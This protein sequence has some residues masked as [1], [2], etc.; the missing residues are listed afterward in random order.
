TEPHG[1]MVV[2]SAAAATQLA[3]GQWAGSEMIGL[4]HRGEP[5]E[6]IVEVAHRLGKSAGLV[7]DTRITHATPAGFAAHQPNRSMENEIAVD[8]LDNR[9]EVMMGGGLRHWT[10]EAAGEAGSAAHAA[11]VQL[12]GGAY[13]GSSRRRDNRN[14]LLEARHEHGYQLAFDRWSLAAVESM[15]LLGV[16]ADSEMQDALLERAARRDE[17]TRHEPSLVEMTAKALELLEQDPDGFFLIVE[18]GQ[19]VWCGHNNGAGGMLHELLR[20][21]AAVRYVLDWARQ[22]DDTLVLVTADHET[23]GFGFS[24]S[25]RPLPAPQTL[26]GEA[27]ADEKFQPNFNY[28][29]PEALDLLYNQQKSFFSMMLEFDA[30]P[31]G[32]QTPEALVKIVNSAS[33]AKI[34]L[35]DAVAVLTRMRNRNYVAGHPF[36]NAPTVPQIRDFESFYV[37]GENLRMNQLGRRLAAQQS[38][39]WSSGTHTSTPVLIGAYGPPEATRCFAGL[40]HATDVGQRMIALLGGGEVRQQAVEAAAT[41]G[42]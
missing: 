29:P 38:V 13:P 35:D 8:M 9:V 39:V 41:A 32:E 21:D 24:Y 25:G 36:L 34:T 10:P 4:N 30:L 23:G 40:M 3:T 1:A 14:L 26:P 7:T 28:A 20:L 16:F 42:K 6:T 11:L 18:G 27:F 12:V 17:A 37:Y 22:R 2:D 5:A 19:I 15:P 31:A 33:Q